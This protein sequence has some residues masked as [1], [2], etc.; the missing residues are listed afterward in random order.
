M[1]KFVLIYH[2]GTSPA[3]DEEKDIM[4][5]AWG[6]WMEDTGE[7]LIDIGNPLGPP[8]SI[9]GTAADPASGYSLIE[10]EDGDQAMALVKDHPMAKEDGARIDIYE[11]FN[12]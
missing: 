11:A 2:G 6:K 10:A 12:M 9:G 8:A 5:A 1:S 3:N 4:M 7:A